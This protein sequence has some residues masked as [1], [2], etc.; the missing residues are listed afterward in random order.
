MENFKL[1]DNLKVKIHIPLSRFYNEHFAN[2]FI[3]IYPSLL[4]SIHLILY[5]FQSKLQT[6]I[7]FTPKHFSIYSLIRIQHFF[8]IL[9]FL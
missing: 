7:Y 2:C 6:L 5:A 8:M 4:L 9:Y 1:A 3:T